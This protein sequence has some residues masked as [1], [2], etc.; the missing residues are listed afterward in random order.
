M[1]F[2]L[3]QIIPNN[4]VVIVKAQVNLMVRFVPY[5]KENSQLW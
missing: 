1:I 4:R 3:K 2:W 5:V